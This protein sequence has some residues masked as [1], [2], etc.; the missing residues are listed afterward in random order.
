M[1][2]KPNYP[3]QSQDKYVLRLPDGMRDKIAALAKAAGRTMNAEI[4][5]R[6]ERSMA[7]DQDASSAHASVEDMVRYFVAK[8]ALDSAEAEYARVKAEFEAKPVPERTPNDTA[9]FYGALGRV[10]YARMAMPNHNLA[11]LRPNRQE[12]VDPDLDEEL[13]R[14]PKRKRKPKS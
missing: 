8:H 9:A 6:L 11:G 7:N 1:N 13:V 5:V 14:S 2:D 3:S 12:P 10:T 4:V